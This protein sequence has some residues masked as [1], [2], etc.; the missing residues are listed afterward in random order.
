MLNIASRRRQACVHGGLSMVELLAALA[1]AS[2]LL[3]LSTTLYLGGKASFRLNEDKR[4][5][6]QDGNYAMILMER[7]LRQAWFGN[8]A[9][10]VSPAG[11]APITDF[12][13]DDG[14]PAQGLRGCEH[15]FVKPLGPGTKDFSCSPEAG[16]AAFE[17]SYRS[18]DYSDPSS[19]AGVDCNGARLAAIAVPP[20][21][22]AYMLGPHVTIARNL[23]FVATRVGG[24]AN[25][26]YCQGNGSAQPVVNNVE[27]LQL[28]FGVAAAGDATRHQFLN[29]TQVAALSDDQRQNW[30]RVV[31]VGL[32]LQLRGENNLAID[33]QRYVDC[34]GSARVASDRRLR[35]VFKRVVTL[36]NRAA[37]MP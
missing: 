8:V 13:L 32:C 36:R 37:A 19:G 9:S 22:P 10:A 7:D 23:Y 1:I 5:L 28:T 25:S 35:A 14:S 15:G 29:A 18:D 11:T 21:H 34:A 30:E 3:L 20:D 2:G 17:V 24:S 33:P 16:M 4:R 31:R 27:D 12:I 6:Y 26:L